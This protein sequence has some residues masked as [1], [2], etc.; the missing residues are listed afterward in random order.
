MVR[1]VF[2]HGTGSIRWIVLDCSVIP[3]SFRKYLCRSVNEYN[4]HNTLADVDTHPKSSGH[5]S[6]RK[7]GSRNRPLGCW[8]SDINRLDAFMDMPEHLS[9]P[10]I[11]PYRHPAP[12]L[13][14]PSRSSLSANSNRLDYTPASL[15]LTVSK[16]HSPHPRAWRYSHF[17]RH[18]PETEWLRIRLLKIMAALHTLSCSLISR[19]HKLTNIRTILA[20]FIGLLSL[21]DCLSM[22]SRRDLN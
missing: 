13:R 6:S 15:V 20:S 5:S 1:L 7:F 18:L 21:S 2:D 3:L 12:P 14:L 8:H 4:P 17:P 9:R 11:P 19:N 10:V 22:I 16:L